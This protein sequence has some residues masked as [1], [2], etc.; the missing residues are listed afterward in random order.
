MAGFPWE[1]N[2]GYQGAQAGCILIVLT[3]GTIGVAVYGVATGEWQ[4]PA[5]AAAIWIGL[6]ASWAVAAAIVIGVLRLLARFA[7]RR[8]K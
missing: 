2:P 5:I 4:L 8:P 7:D 6:F 1:E 3:L